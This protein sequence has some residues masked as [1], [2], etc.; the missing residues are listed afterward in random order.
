[1]A[2]V[3]KYHTDR[4]FFSDRLKER[5]ASVL[6]S[7]FTIVEAPSGFGKTTA[8]RNLLDQVDDEVYYITVENDNDTLLFEEF[9][10]F[11][12][13]ID[14]KL[15]IALKNIGC[16]KDAETA[17]KIIRLF[18]E[19][20]LSEHFILVFDNFQFVNNNDMKSVI[21][22]LLDFTGENLKIILITQ[23]VRYEPFIE[24]IME[25]KVNY[26]GKNDLEFSSEEIKEYFKEC[27]IKLKDEEADFLFKYTEG[28]IS[29][30]YLQM[31][32]YLTD[33]KF[34]ADTGIN[35]LVCTAIWDK[36]RIDEQDFMLSIAIFDSFSIK[37]AIFMGSEELDIDSIKRLL[38]SNS[39][40]RYDSQERRYYAHALLRYFLKVEFDKIDSIIR[41]QIF[42]R[43]AKWF[44]QNEDYCRA[45]E[46][47]YRIKKYDDVYYMKFSMEDIIG[48]VSKDHKETFL[49]LVSNASYDAK[50]K[51]I[52][53]SIIMCFILY[54]YNEKEFFE[55]ECIMIQDIIKNSKYLKERERDYFLGEITFIRSYLYYNNIEK[56]KEMYESAYQLLKSP[57][58]IY[59]RHIGITFRTPSVLDCFYSGSNTVMEELKQFE[60]MMIL[61]YKITSGDCKGSEAVM[62]AEI[63]YNQGNY[64]DAE[65]LCQKALYIAETRQQ[66]VT[67]I[68]TM[69]LMAK[70][71][72]FKGDYD[73]MK[74]IIESIRKKAVDEGGSENFFMADLCEGY[75]YML[76]G[77]MDNVPAWLRDEKTIEEKTSVFSLA[78]A[79][80]I[81]AKYLIS[82][83]SYTKLLGISGQMLGSAGIHH[84]KMYEIYLYIYISIANFKQGNMLKASKFMNNAVEIA[85]K[86]GFVQPFIENYAYISEIHF[87]TDAKEATDFIEKVK[88]LY[89]KYEKEYKT[90]M[91][92]YRE[93]KDY[94]LTN[95]ELQIAKLAARRFTNKEIAD[96]LYI[97]V[98]T[99]KSTLKTIFGKLHINSRGELKD[100]FEE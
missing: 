100:F 33:N 52:R 13:K 99:V 34:E 27:G 57:S 50:E 22:Q 65:I 31:L 59:S 10:D 74:Y 32:H 49:K 42:E 14:I 70:I 75:L 77:K 40:I 44:E 53:T 20:E 47:Y 8:V 71:A 29:A 85:Y 58:N 28:W 88:N 81:Y 35:N 72:V 69:F 12:Q 4:F 79:D 25:N 45:L 56:M 39:F 48:Y 83:G 9:C 60:Q 63:L 36:L 51:N 93:D 15:S 91:N 86:E 95:R 62:R 41:R 78:F 96:Q 80:I 21:F 24:M 30:I 92:D 64:D 11:V 26:I 84:N 87:T 61:Y 18:A 90:I 68:S 94:G 55:N 16:P 82:N 1:M 46:Y 97:A 38:S 23:S 3:K 66:T 19:M 54:M 43:A 98:G 5:L 67:Y 7:N 73:N 89:K 17:S 6:E 76:L 2:V 37:Q